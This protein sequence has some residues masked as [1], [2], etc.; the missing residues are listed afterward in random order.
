MGST[1]RIRTH[2]PKETQ[3]VGQ[4]VG[5]QVRSG[6]ILLLTGPLGAGKTCLAQGIAC[7]LG[8][9]GHIR[10]PS[11]VLMSRHRGRLTLYHLDLYRINDPLEAWDLGLEEQLFDEG[12]CVV[13]W[14]DRAA[15]L[16]PEACLW[17]SL[18]YGQDQQDRII[19]LAE[20]PSRY[21]PIL[22]KLS[23][24]FPAAEVKP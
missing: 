20:P 10:S 19:I 9:A 12:V 8:V 16:F 2:S 5:A 21:R 3:E 18:D 4:V 23:D 17:I 1:L 7:G 14:A 6:D 15:D 11:F 24:A 22:E 13:E